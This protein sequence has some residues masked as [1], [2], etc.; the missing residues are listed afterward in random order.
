[1]GVD[2]GEIVLFSDFE[3]DGEM[4][5]GEGPR[6]TRALVEFSTSFASVPVVKVDL[7]M[8]DMSNAANMRVDVAAES[9]TTDSFAVVFRTW[10][11]SK[12]ARVR[13]GWLA[14]GELPDDELWDV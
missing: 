10:G 1:M 14:F 8:W 11:D 3:H 6:M 9:V 2:Q 5:T 12:V 13:V 4:W 7:S